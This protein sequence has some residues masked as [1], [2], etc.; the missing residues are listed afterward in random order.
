MK[1]RLTDMKFCKRVMEKPNSISLED[2]YRESYWDL[3]FWP[4]EDLRAALPSRL[5]ETPELEARVRLVL[6]AIAQGLDPLWVRSRL[7]SWGVHPVSILLAEA[8]PKHR[9]DLA[10]SLLPD[11]GEWT[12]GNPTVFRGSVLPQGCVIPVQFVMDGCSGLVELPRDL[13]A[14]SLL[15]QNCSDLRSIHQLSEGVTGLRIENVPNLVDLPDTLHLKKGFYLSACP[16]LTRLPSDIRADEIRI[17]HCPGIRAIKAKIQCSTFILKN[18]IHL[19]D[20]DLDLK[21]SGGL[22]LNLPSLQSLRGRAEI[23]GRLKIS[24]RKLKDVDAAISVSDDA[25]I[26]QC[27]SLETIGGMLHV[28]GNLRIGQNPNLAST[29]DGFV[30]GTLELIDLKSLRQVRPLLIASSRTVRIQHCPSL[31]KMPHGVH[32]RGSLEL[33][34]L[35][36]ISHWP[37][38]MS[39]G[40]LTVLGC[41]GLPDPPPGVIIRTAFRRAGAHEREAL[42]QLVGQDIDNNQ[43]ARDSLRRV[44]RTLTVTGLSF[45]DI[46]ELLHAEGHNPGEVI[47]AAAAEG[48]GV[49]EYLEECADLAFNPEGFIK[50]ARLCARA[51][52]HPGSIAL[53]VKNLT[54]ARWVAELYSNSSDLAAGVRGDGSLSIPPNP[55]WD[56]PEG[57]AVPGQLLAIDATGPAMWPSGLR[58]V[59]GFKTRV[60]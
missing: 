54:K 59:G 3:P 11:D 57:L 22:E 56:L 30:D 43:V 27:S 1:G 38:S 41:P 33:L 29:P 19:T 5:A 40:I 13:I 51:S 32:I 50:A 44:I 17:S 52:I 9:A 47:A 10:S 21:V 28:K 45:Q 39:V 55:A 23:S 12:V 15:I 37:D 31:E 16:R 25:I 60:A 42:L 4:D 46:R 49:R 18:L 2:S 6:G 14:K 48:L 35:Q 26:E 34:D 36:S 24:C 7:E 20:L 53:V 8:H 58:A